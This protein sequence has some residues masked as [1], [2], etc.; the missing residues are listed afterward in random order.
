MCLI[1]CAV[2]SFDD[3]EAV[4][5]VLC[6]QSGVEDEHDKRSVRKQRNFFRLDSAARA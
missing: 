2:C 6:L 3:K 1:D 5:E 4:G